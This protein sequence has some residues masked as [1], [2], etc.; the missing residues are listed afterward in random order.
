M[1][2]SR[3]PRALCLM[4][5]M[6]RRRPP[7]RA[8][9]LLAATLPLAAAGCATGNTGL[10]RAEL[11]HHAAARGLPAERV[12]LPFAVDDEMRAWLGEEIDHHGRFPQRLE[13]LLHALLAPEERGV[14]YE[15]G[16]T[17][18]AAEAFEQRRA[19]CLGFTNLFIA[20][21]RE[22]G[23]PVYFLAVDEVEDFEKE[24]DLVVVS[25][26][27]T[28][29]YGPSHELTVLE[30]SLGPNVDYRSLRK[31]DDVTAAALYYSNRGAE[32]VRAGEI[33]E[34]R[35]MLEVATGLDGELPIAWVNLGVALR[36]GNDLEGAEL[37]YRRALEIDPRTP[38]A[39]HNLASLLQLRGREREADELL[40]EISRFGTRNPYNYL[41]LGDRA[42]ERGELERAHRFYRKALRLYRDDPEPYAA[43]G[44]WAWEAGDPEAA[45]LW[46]E[47]A[48][49]RGAENERVRELAGRLAPPRPARLP[50]PVPA[51]AGDGGG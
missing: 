47:R 22:I 12:V 29:G 32:L 9:L 33:E 18:T 51:W 34:A 46:L 6:T 13:L 30:F 2:E 24:R 21:A 1:E 43:L 10:T 5:T 36:R 16:F 7:R 50:E 37:A 44:R 26:H 4:S 49:R 48:R 15:P 45:R 27:V 41:T 8:V 3:P 28:A 19:N 38:S 20:L 17:G 42:L 31:L 40:A 14:T 11:A 35:R 39:Y 25:R 23:V